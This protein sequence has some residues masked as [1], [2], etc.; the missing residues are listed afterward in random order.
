MRRSLGERFWTKVD[1]RGPD[2]CWLWTASRVKQGYGTINE[3]GWHGKILRAHRVAWMLAH[4]VIP[5]DLDILHHCDNPPCVN[6][7]HLF[8]GDDSINN[9]DMWNKGRANNLRGENHPASKLTLEQVNLILALDRCKVFSRR[10]IGATF[11][12]SHWAVRD[13]ILGK[14]WANVDGVV[15]A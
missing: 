2:E 9:A 10:T 6:E 7:R 13:I 14:S 15:R 5:D 4:G 1:K 3:G 12:V 11:G 8:L